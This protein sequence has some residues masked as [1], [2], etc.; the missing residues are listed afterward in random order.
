MSVLLPHIA[1]RLFN[2]PLMVAEDKLTA[3]L[4]GLGARVVEG[5]LILA[6]A[7][8]GGLADPAMG[9]LG[10]PTGRTFAGNRPYHVVNGIAVLG[11]EGTL[12]HKGA[13]VG[14]SSGQTSHQG[15]QVQA[16]RALADPEIKGAVYEVDSFGGQVAGAFEAAES[17]R[18]L[19]KAKPTMAILT[20]FALSC[21]YLMASTARQVII[22]PRGAAGSIGVISVHADFSKKLEQDGIKVTL[23]TAGKNKADGHP[24]VPLAEHV[25]EAAKVRNEAVRQTFAATVAAY[26]GSRLTKAAALATEAAVFHGP[27]AVAAGLVDAVAD[28]HQAFAAFSR[29]VHQAA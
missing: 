6:N 24:A 14:Q 22:P 26:R 18:A 15:L 10:D 23:I 1:S 11:V 8:S 9:K 16:V 27:E 5:G 17:L 4:L 20:D 12:V 7:P 13:Y 2:E 3:I 21:G 28:P 19:S 29:A 25:Y